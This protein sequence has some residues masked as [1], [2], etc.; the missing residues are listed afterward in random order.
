MKFL[1]LMCLDEMAGAQV[2]QELI[3]KGLAE[4]KA[5]FDWL[6]TTGRL[7]AVNTLLRSKTAR[8]VRVRNGKTIVTDGPFAETKEAIGGYFLIEARDQEE[9]NDIASRFPGAQWG[10]VEVRRVDE[11]PVS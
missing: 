1:C 2:P 4:C 9:A 7:V 3:D 8:T 11:P 10:C 6:Q 5:F